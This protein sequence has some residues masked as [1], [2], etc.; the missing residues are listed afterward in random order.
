M[1]AIENILKTAQSQGIRAGIYTFTA[2]YARRMIEMGFDYVVISSDARLI[3]AQAKQVLADFR[4][5]K[6]K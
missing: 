2:A 6:I 1:N 5:Q 3:A 4:L